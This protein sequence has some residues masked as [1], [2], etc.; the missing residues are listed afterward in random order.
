VHTSA[1][2]VCRPH[3]QGQGESSND[4]IRPLTILTDSIRLS[5]DYLFV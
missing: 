5:P 2:E 3:P 4:K 1:Y